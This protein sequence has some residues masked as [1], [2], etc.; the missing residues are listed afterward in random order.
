VQ[1]GSWGRPADKGNEEREWELERGATPV[2]R[3]FL[4]LRVTPG[5]EGPR[6]RGAGGGRGTT[7][8]YENSCRLSPTL[9]DA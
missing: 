8:G 4:A 5:L 3:A 6:R 9:G 1:Q 2:A 7:P